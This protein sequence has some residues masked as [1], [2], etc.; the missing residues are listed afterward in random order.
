[1]GSRH[2]LPRAPIVGFVRAVLGRGYSASLRVRVRSR[3]FGARWVRASRP[4]LGSFAPFWGAGV[5]ASHRVWVR[6]RG[7]QGLAPFCRAVECMG[8]GRALDRLARSITPGMI[9]ETVMRV[10][11]IF[12]DSRG[13]G[14]ERSGRQVDAISS[15]SGRRAKRRAERSVQEAPVTATRVCPRCGAGRMV[16]IAEF[17]PSTPP[18]GI[19][20]DREPLRILDSS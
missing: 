13:C 8:G 4:G 14:W 15:G 7:F 5:P 1:M 2:S 3:G 16:V 9:C 19:A 6:S 11:E 10:A 20:V 18:E 12:S 17:P